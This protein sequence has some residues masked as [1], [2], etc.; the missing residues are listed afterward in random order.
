MPIIKGQIRDLIT[1][2][3]N[4]IELSMKPTRLPN[5]PCE[6]SKD[7]ISTDPIR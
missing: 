5:E 6:E 3:K 2:F 4:K 1:E 7:G